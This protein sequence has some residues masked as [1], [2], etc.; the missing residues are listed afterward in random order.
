MLD[1]FVSCMLYL[2][3]ETVLRKTNISIN[4]SESPYSEVYKY[5][6]CRQNSNTR[7]ESDGPD[8]HTPYT[9]K[10]YTQ[11]HTPKCKYSD[12]LC[13][14]TRKLLRLFFIT[15][16]AESVEMFNLK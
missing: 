5:L 4:S 9:I 16:L 10:P 12:Q 13:S 2:Y 7:I 14:I 8:I 6:K 11:H 3:S 15:E 1:Y